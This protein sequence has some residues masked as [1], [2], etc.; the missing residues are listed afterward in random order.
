MRYTVIVLIAALTVTFGCNPNYDD[1]LVVEGRVDSLE[2][3]LG[4]RYGQMTLK[5]GRTFVIYGSIPGRIGGRDY[6]VRFY[7]ESSCEGN[8][9]PPMHCVEVDSTKIL[10]NPPTGS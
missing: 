6:L 5:D 7:M 3:K 2:G 9:S 4:S 10:E 8:L 1:K